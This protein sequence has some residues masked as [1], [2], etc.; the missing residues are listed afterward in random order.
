MKIFLNYF[1]FLLLSINLYAQTPKDD[2]RFQRDELS[3]KDNEKDCILMKNDKL[4]IIVKGQ[5]TAMT[6]DYTLTNGDVVTKEGKVIAKDGSSKQMKNGDCITFAGIWSHYPENS[7][8][9]T[10]EEKKDSS[11]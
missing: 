7:K 11:E 3:K 1:L 8:T 5:M 2:V 10:L 4:F 6:A 9:K